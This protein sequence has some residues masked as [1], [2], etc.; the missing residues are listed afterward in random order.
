[1]VRQLVLGAALLIALALFPLFSPWSTVILT[2][3]LCEG[4][5]ALGIMVLLRAGQVSFGHGLFFSFSAYA[6]AFMA[7]ARLGHE[8]LILIPVATAASG[9]LAAIVGLFIVRYRAIFFGMLNLAISMVF[10]SLLEKLFPITGGADGKRVPRP[11]LAG[12][13][14]GREQFEL[15]IFYITLGLCLVAA[16]FVARYLTSPGGKALEAIKSNETRLEYLGVS[17]R[18]VLFGAY[19]LSGLLAGLGGAVIA[20]VSGHVTPELAYWVRSGE[21]VFIAILGGIGGVAGPFLGALMFQIIR[22]YAAVYAPE[23]WHA[24]LGVMLLAIIFFAPAGLYGIATG[25]RRKEGGR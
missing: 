25:S 17:P 23:T 6:V 3:A 24:V 4:L 19:L 14:F 20:L 11:T 10:F 1:M 5:A 22:G 7:A 16:L 12:M 2:V 21:F 18:K 9:L 15:W 13:E 8:A